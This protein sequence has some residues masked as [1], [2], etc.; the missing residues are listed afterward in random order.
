[1]AENHFRKPA[2]TSRIDRPTRS[3]LGLSLLLILWVAV[4]A[5]SAPADSVVRGQDPSS[6]DGDRQ[7][8]DLPSTDSGEK[9]IELVDRLY[10]ET[11]DQ[12]LRRLAL[13]R[14][15]E[16]F[17]DDRLTAFRVGV[18]LAIIDWNE[19]RT[20][21]AHDRLARLIAGNTKRLDREIYSWAEVVDGRVLADLGRT[22][23]ALELLERVA[24]DESL[25]SARRAEGAIAAADIRAKG[26]PQAALASLEQTESQ[27]GL[28][29]PAI[30]AGIA[31]LL[32]VTGRQDEL[33]Q[34]IS[35]IS[36]NRS[37]G[38]EA[39]AEV[40]ENARSWMAPGDAA[41]ISL[42]VAA[43]S[44][45]RPAPGERLQKAVANCG[46]A[47]TELSVQGRLAKLL[48][49]KPLSDWYRRM[50]SDSQT[51]LESFTA[52]IKQASH[53]SDPERCL[54]LSLRALASTRTDNTFTRR[55][56][57]A[58]GFADW[59][60]R[61]RPGSIDPLVCT[62]LLDLCDQFT[63]TN[64]YFTEGKFIRAERLARTGDRVG[65]R[66][67]LADIL[68][69]PGQS[70]NY[71]A[72]ACRMLGESHEL[73]G[74][75]RQA[76]EVY[77]Q[78]EP[79]ALSHTAGALCIL[80]AAWINL[81]L[82]NSLE[83]SRLIG[84]LSRAP[85]SVTRQ[86][87]C[88]AQLREL[89]TL[90]RIGRAEECW[91]A[92]RTWWTEWAK[93]AVGLGAPTN[94]PEYAVPEIDN[95]PGL[96]DAIR[97][98][99]Q[100][101]DQAAYVKHLSVL[102]SAARWQPSLCPEAAALCTATLKSAPNSGDD[103]RGFLIRM[104]ASPHPQEISGLRERKLC[105]AVNYLDVHQYA[106][107]LRLAADFCADKQPEDNTTRAMHRVRALAALAAG[108]DCA[109]SIADLEKDLSDPD[110][111]VQRTMAVGL[112]S[113]IYEKIGRV[114][115]STKLLQ[116]ELDNPA[117]VADGEG[118]TLLRSRLER[119]A[120]L[121]IRPPPVDKWV[122]SAALN[123]YDYA[124]PK[125]L[126]DQRLSNLEE[127]LAKSG[128]DFSPTEQTK[129]LLLAAGDS[130]RSPEDRNRSFLEAAVRIIGWAPNY[131]RMQVLAGSVI[132]DP[133]FELQTRLGLLWNVLTILA[134]D[135]RRADYDSL[136]K[137][138]L[139]GALSP[140][141]KGRLGWLDREAALDRSSPK[142]ILAFAEALSTQELA[143][144]EVLIMQDC[145]GFLVR[146]G[147][148]P[149]AEAL[150]NKAASW[151]FA[152]ETAPTAD[153]VRLEI[154]RQI[155]IAKTLNP[156]HEALAAGVLAQFAE[157][158][159]SLPAE[160]ANLRIDSRMPSRSQEATFNACLRL[161]SIRQFER[162]DLQFWSPFLQALPEGNSKAIGSLIR[163]GL[164]AAG[165]DDVRSQL[166]MLF[167]T[168]LNV[169]DPS[170]RQAMEPE[171]ARCRDPV[172]SPLSYMMIR[173]YEIHRDLRLGRQATLES[174]FMDLND[175]RALIVK[176][177]ACLRHYTQT[178]ERELLR[179]T[180]DQINSSQ[181]L[182]PG[183]LSQA[184]PAL[185]LL[186]MAPEL[187]AAREAS[188]RIVRAEV[189]DSWARGNES[190]GEAA[191]ELALVLGD[192][193]I[194]PRA[195]VDEMGS[196][197]GN[198]LFQGRVLLDQAYLES[199]WAR[200]A[201]LAGALTR[202]YP[203]RYSFYWYLGI[204]LHHLGRESEAA[205]ALAPYLKY[206]RD[207]FEYPKALELAKTLPEAATASF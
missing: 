84:I 57:E 76:L 123:W 157:R 61:K 34:R 107:V 21:R 32:L 132:N 108:S 10:P 12:I 31:R 158:P 185:E 98:S 46:R 67:V 91:S 23:E 124:E 43:V 59:A 155:R 202:S 55:V 75:Y 82:G 16:Y 18:R 183:F 149:E 174:A 110:A 90:V 141:F 93:I 58:A 166:I 118:R 36:G 50:P 131:G 100:E 144:S 196:G 83:A 169:D 159:S 30:E 80:H 106:E 105:L 177:R 129:L 156:V 200:V 60:E 189:L 151:R 197:D 126:D 39:L 137:N 63:P 103:I 165:D 167:F 17:P 145:L 94:L 7:T 142:E 204:A 52:A 120:S 178:G 9:E 160:Y 138:D 20:S 162:N 86:L 181:L 68:A 8:V 26:S 111:A 74:E 206:A 136:R 176:Q 101:G 89:V 53:N 115:D 198:P 173:F 81:S 22:P 38:E 24:R 66:R 6:G 72:P 182:S 2:Q 164:D 4:C 33:E 47:A 193:S 77:A 205:G 116:R 143:A 168:S 187:K 92:G 62:V 112:L 194:L 195:W 71:L 96:E 128:R 79:V 41:R 163:A 25:P 135:G 73:A 5:P 180:I 201:N 179:R 139:C 27:S 88:S 87:G 42:L 56:W 97:R 171:F 13:E 186:D 170:V 148:I 119:L 54:R 125:N 28:S 64:P 140:E 175:P 147:A 134:R 3:H 154:G 121:A 133:S 190:A 114:G 69:V 15:L 146:I 40:L 102:M 35:D 203:S 207:E 153:A 65:E 113:D 109:A 99:A 19:G 188:A 199:D 95:V 161:I 150:G 152:S 70:D 172:G 104:L 122:R 192:K 14:V 127:A 1:M 85:G 130:R 37:Q 48:R 191:L 44:K 29:G 117:V 78:A 45:A 51:S 184:L 11:G 49:V